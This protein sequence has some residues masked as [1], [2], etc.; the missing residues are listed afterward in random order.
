MSENAPPA[1]RFYPNDSALSRIAFRP[2]GYLILKIAIFL[3]ELR[4][5]RDLIPSGTGFVKL[6]RPP[7]DC[8]PRQA[9]LIAARFDAANNTKP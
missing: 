3:K 1:R 5:G 8:A 6:F 7:E 9:L 4:G 2:K